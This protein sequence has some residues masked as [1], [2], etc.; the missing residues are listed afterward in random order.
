MAAGG[1]DL[2]RPFCPELAADVGEVAVHAFV[3]GIERGRFSPAPPFPAV[4]G[5][6]PPSRT[7]TVD[8]VQ[9]DSVNQ[10]RLACVG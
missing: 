8:R 9:L 1:G 4:S 5:Q 6:T 2:E 10:R 7:A 3:A